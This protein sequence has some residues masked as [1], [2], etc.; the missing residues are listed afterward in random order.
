M[1]SAINTNNRNILIFGDD[2]I[3]LQNIKM[4]RR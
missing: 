2:D 1:S 4:V 3:K